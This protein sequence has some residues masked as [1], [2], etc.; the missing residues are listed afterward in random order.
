ML[1]PEH[2]LVLVF[3]PMLV[4]VLP[5]MLQARGTL[6]CQQ[7]RPFWEVQMNCRRQCTVPDAASASSFAFAF[8]FAVAFGFLLA[9]DSAFARP[10]W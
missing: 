1:T 5:L 10:R 6:R 2:G 8:E 9:L 7:Q 4:L 3:V